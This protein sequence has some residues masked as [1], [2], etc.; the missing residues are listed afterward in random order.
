MSYEEVELTEAEKEL[1]RKAGQENDDFYHGLGAMIRAAGS[2]DR[3][4]WREVHEI[5]GT[6]VVGGE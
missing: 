6:S 2:R 4:M 3:Q 5:A 1:V